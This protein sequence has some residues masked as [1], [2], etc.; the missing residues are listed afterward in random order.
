M[1]AEVN[2]KVRGV[3]GGSPSWNPNKGEVITFVDGQKDYISVDAYKGQGEEY[4]R[5]DKSKIEISISGKI[6][7]FDDIEELKKQLNK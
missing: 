1:K 5:R 6:Y 3:K 2:L 7:S 4:K